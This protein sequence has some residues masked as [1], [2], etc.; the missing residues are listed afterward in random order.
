MTLTQRVYFTIRTHKH[1]VCSTANTHINAQQK[2]ALCY[3]SSM[4]AWIFFHHSLC[5]EYTRWLFRYTMWCFYCSSH[6][7]VAAADVAVKCQCFLTTIPTL[8]TFIRLIPRM[9]LSIQS[10]KNAT[11]SWTALFLPH[12]TSYAHQKLTSSLRLLFATVPY[13]LL[14]FPH[15][16]RTF[17]NFDTQHN[18]IQSSVC[19]YWRFAWIPLLYR[20]V[21]ENF[22]LRLK[23]D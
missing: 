7:C 12:I 13:L 23:L 9:S 19:K 16:C 1:T 10:T 20:C 4:W 18:G 8:R 2:R 21:R 11:K 14:F 3:L 15:L 22:Q 17:R 5:D 6:F